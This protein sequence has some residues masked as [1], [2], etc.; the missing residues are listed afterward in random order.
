MEGFSEEDTELELIEKVGGQDFQ[1]E[2]I[3]GLR[4]RLGALLGKRRRVNWRSRGD[5]NKDLCEA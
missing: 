3:I 1:K 5:R 4:R 2:N